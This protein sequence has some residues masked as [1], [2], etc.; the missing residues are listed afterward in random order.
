MLDAFDE[1]HR[2]LLPDDPVSE[3]LG[4]TGAEALLFALAR[5]HDCRSPL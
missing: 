4:S 2:A 3:S 5:G 1:P